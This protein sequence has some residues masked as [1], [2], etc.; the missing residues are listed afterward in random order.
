MSG[1]ACIGYIRLVPCND[2]SVRGCQKL[3]YGDFFNNLLIIYS[4]RPIIIL[5]GKSVLNV[6]NCIIYSS[7]RSSCP[8]RESLSELKMREL[9]CNRSVGK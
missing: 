9:K 5:T 7:Q 3:L 6:Q 1:Y 8:A 4:N 2:N